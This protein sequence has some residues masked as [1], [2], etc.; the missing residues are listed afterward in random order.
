MLKINLGI[1]FVLAVLIM[2]FYA[3]TTI[4]P[5]PSGGPFS[6]NTVDGPISLDDFNGQWLV[7]YF[8]YASCP[9]VCPTDLARWNQ[10]FNQLHKEGVHDI[11]MMFVS[12][13]FERDTP[14]LL[15]QYAQYFNPNFKAATADQ[16]E[17]TQVAQAYGV[18][19]E[20]VYQS[21]SAMSYSI[22]HSTY[23]YLINPDGKLVRM[24]KQTTAVEALTN[25][26]QKQMREFQSI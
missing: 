17:I 16:T 14:E 12:V 18:T 22:D 4:K 6:L 13:D 11:A 1:A 5:T 26:I 2:G 19:W 25:E 3:L 23:S 21:N 15:A 9:D 7:L 10:V 8:G 20:K 24:F